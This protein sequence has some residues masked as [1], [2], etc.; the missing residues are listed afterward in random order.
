MYN[1]T[2]MMLRQYCFDEVLTRVSWFDRRTGSCRLAVP[3][4]YNVSTAVVPVT[5]PNSNYLP[6]Q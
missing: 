4:Y 5:G 3:I 1:I 2:R 6:I